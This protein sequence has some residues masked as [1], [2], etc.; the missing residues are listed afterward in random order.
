MV[1]K[2]KKDKKNKKDKINKKDKK[3]NREDTDFKLEK[4]GND[5][6][7]KGEVYKY[8]KI[9]LIAPIMLII[10]LFILQTQIH[11]FVPEF[12]L[13]LF[14]EFENFRNGYI[15]QNQIIYISTCIL[16]YVILLYTTFASFSR[17]SSFYMEIGTDTIT[18]QE[19]D[20]LNI[21]KYDELYAIELKKTI[22][23]RIFGYYNIKMTHK[24]FGDKFIYFIPTPRKMLR[25]INT[26]IQQREMNQTNMIAERDARIKR[27]NNIR[28]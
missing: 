22:W 25:K 4:F 26:L 14:L 18:I 24:V 16:L 8:S 7:K 10:A 5:N 11:I 9:I 2:D 21:A 13:S 15:E 6:K 28:N 23:G 27:L 20:I 19:D 17:Y 3:K 12:Q 1:K